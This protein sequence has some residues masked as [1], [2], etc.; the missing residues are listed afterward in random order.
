[1]KKL[2]VIIFILPFI[3]FSQEQLEGVV[4]ETVDALETLAASEALRLSRVKD[5]K[6]KQK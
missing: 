4:L 2:I 3:S 5:K 1:M 6:Q